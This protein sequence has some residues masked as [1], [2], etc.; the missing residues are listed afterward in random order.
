MAA[1]TWS[2]QL[3]ESTKRYAAVVLRRYKKLSLSS[4]V[5][6]HF[7]LGVNMLITW[8]SPALPMASSALLH[9]PSSAHLPHHTRA[10]RA[11]SVRQGTAHQQFTL[12]LA[13]LLL[14]NT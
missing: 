8:V 6:L 12:W 11:V 2:S 1:T 9:M 14:R 4:K 7:S 3:Y 13:N 10:R 5:C